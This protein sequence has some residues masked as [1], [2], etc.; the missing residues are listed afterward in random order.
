MAVWFAGGS[1]Q[2]CS[3]PPLRTSG[4]GQRRGSVEH[5]PRSTRRPSHARGDAPREPWRALASSTRRAD[6]PRAWRGVVPSPFGGGPRWSSVPLGIAQR[7]PIRAS[8]GERLRRRPGRIGRERT[9][10]SGPSLSEHTGR[11]GPQHWGSRPNRP[12]IG[13]F[14]PQHRKPIRPAR[15]KRPRRRPPSE[16]RIGRC[17]A[18]PSSAEPQRGPSPKEDEIPPSM[19]ARSPLRAWR[20]RP[21]ARDRS[22]RRVRARVV[23]LE[24]P[25]QAL[26]QLGP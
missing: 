22:A 5:V 6:C 7:R 11:F 18:I 3:A 25:G 10:E 24:K 12:L 26:H 21:R 8:A 1:A 2:W 9:A 16:A 13:R 14:G 15:P 20:T 19:L 4:R 23:V 17:C